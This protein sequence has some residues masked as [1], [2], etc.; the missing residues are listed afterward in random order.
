[1]QYLNNDI[2]D[3][4]RRASEA[5]PLK[6][7]PDRWEEISG[8]LV[9][10]TGAGHRTFV[11][12][13]PAAFMCVLIFAFLAVNDSLHINPISNKFAVA[14]NPQVENIKQP[15]N[16]NHSAT[17]ESK[18]TPSPNKN[19]DKQ[20]L[21][22]FAVNLS[23]T[24]FIHPENN[25]EKNSQPALQTGKDY[26]FSHVELL[27]LKEKGV[28]KNEIITPGRKILVNKTLN[29]ALVIKTE[30]NE[31]MPVATPP[32]QK[33]RKFYFGISAGIN[34][35]AV[36]SGNFG[37]ATSQLGLVAGYQL[38]KKMSVETGLLLSKKNYT[39]SGAYFNMKN[40]QSSMPAGMDIMSLT[41]KSK[42]LEIPVQVSYYIL[43][44]NK[45]QMYVKSGVSSF[46]IHNEKNQYKTLMNGSEGSMD[47]SYSKN[48]FYPA[49]SLNL[50]V[51]YEKIITSSAGI[52]VEPFVQ[53]PLKGM[54]VGKLP[55]KN[56]G[57][58]LILFHQN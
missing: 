1:M 38:N 9:E 41:G 11:A 40:M 25:R 15:G 10:T 47:A 30:N 29:A 7:G 43:N 13:K 54:G 23:N 20:L 12:W 27:S 3:I 26:K 24:L 48:K 2:E 28:L 57:L 45:H 21:S 6:N 16:E 35:S 37:K 50:A 22:A 39:S 8:K 4:F 51:G 34:S 56:I 32:I 49:A 46:V 53:L 52:R 58:R 17:E 36:K 33:N 42:F 44:G 55:F 31:L 19:H 14:E 5:Y 18:I